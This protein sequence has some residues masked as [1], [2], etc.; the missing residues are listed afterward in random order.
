[1][2]ERFEQKIRSGFEQLGI[3]ADHDTAEKLFRYYEMLIEKNKVMNLTAITEED[4]V[5]TKHIIDSVSLVACLDRK[6][7]ENAKVIDVGTGAGLP[8][9]ILKIV[10]PNM[11][12]TLFDSLK[13][14][15]VFLEEVISV[16]GLKEVTTVHGRA[17]DYGRDKKMRESYDLAVSRAVANMSSLSE[18]CLPFVKKNGYFAAYKS[19]ESQEE[20]RNAGNALKIL[21]GEIEKDAEFVLPDSDIRRRIVL[22][23]K[24]RQT[25]A[26][27]PRK[28]GVPA[29]EPLK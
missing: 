2:T 28:A 7:L 11:K 13:K 21:G 23:R 9:M 6:Y 22:V 3:P 17:E 14:R 27:Y 4:E 18:Y 25:P 19:A 20:I 24:V 1:M 5:I 26:A 29:K 8:G 15:L 10:F 12:M 16:L